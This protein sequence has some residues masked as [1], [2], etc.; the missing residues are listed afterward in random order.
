MRPV[1]ILAA[2]LA[3]LLGGIALTAWVAREGVVFDRRVIAGWSFA[4]RTGSEAV[5]PYARAR[6]LVSGELPLANGEG[7]SLVA[8]RDYRGQ[9]LEGRCIY[10][11]SG[12]M[13]AARFWTLSLTG[14]DG[15]AF[16][17]PIGRSS[18]T[19][20]EIIRHGDGGFAITLSPLPQ[21]GNWL[22]TPS[23]GPFV[24]TLRFY[25]TPLSATATVLEPRMLPQLRRVA[26]AP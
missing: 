9:P 13:P 7:F 25:E 11:F 23:E 20:S 26:C 19:S 2:V 21:A 5:D 10:G 4:P 3:G 16:T 6:M 17:T 8:E 12:A 18:F 24:L 15:Q 1:T 22:P 14:P